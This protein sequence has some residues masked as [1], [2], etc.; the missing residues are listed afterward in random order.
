M[1]STATPAPATRK[2]YTV[3]PS[4][5]HNWA[6]CGGFF[7]ASSREGRGRG[8]SYPLLLGTAVHEL[9]AAYDRE[10]GSGGQAT[11]T[12]LA[13]HWR[14]GRFEPADDGRAREE[15][16][17]MLGLYARSQ[18]A[19][20]VEVLAS[21]HAAQIGPRV[22]DERRA[23]ILSGR[24]DRVA[25]RADGTLEVLDFKTAAIL[26][27]EDE[28]RRDPA[29]AAYHLLAE[30]RFGPGPLVVAQW[31]LRSDARVEACLSEADLAAGKDRLRAMVEDLASGSF[32]TTL[33]VACGYCPARD[34]CP[35]LLDG[36]EVADRAW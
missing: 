36:S 27:S 5:A 12:L 19:G 14:A 32:G 10:R 33:G 13:R 26:P 20:M 21:E 25:R 31:S 4:N 18:Q 22:L 6:I 11:S 7:D 9:V 24:I 30:G 16:G 29:T 35:A 15:A 8:T 3:T 2:V 34:R 17:T 23:I 1:P 28:L